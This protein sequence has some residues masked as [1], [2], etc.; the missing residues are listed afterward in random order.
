M[1]YGIVLK[2]NK[3]PYTTDTDENPYGE[4]NYVGP[5]TAPIIHGVAKELLDYVEPIEGG[6]ERDRNTK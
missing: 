4:G 5:D 3:A 6:K 2:D 1:L